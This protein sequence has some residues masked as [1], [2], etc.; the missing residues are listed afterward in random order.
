[1]TW[2]LAR[3]LASSRSVIELAISERPQVIAKAADL[4]HRG[5]VRLRRGSPKQMPVVGQAHRLPHLPRLWAGKRSA[6]PTTLSFGAK[7]RA[8]RSSRRNDYRIPAMARSNSCR[9]VKFVSRFRKKNGKKACQPFQDS[10]NPGAPQKHR[11]K[12]VLTRFWRFS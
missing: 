9:F 8:S 1:M 12:K 5:L 2:E 7:P 3:Q 10:L 6:R 11:M 4:L